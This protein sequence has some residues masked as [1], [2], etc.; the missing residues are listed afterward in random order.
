MLGPSSGLRVQTSYFLCLTALRPASRP[1]LLRPSRILE[2]PFYFQLLG[3]PFLV[4][5]AR[6]LPPDSNT[7]PRCK[8]NG[9][10]SRRGRIARRAPVRL[11]KSGSGRPASGPGVTPL[12]HSGIRSYPQS[13]ARVTPVT[14]AGFSDRNPV[15][16]PSRSWYT[17]AE[18][19]TREL[20]WPH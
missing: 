14:P 18:Y 19:R 5:P 13:S 20:W 15:T 1:R 17:A 12:S 16:A 2:Y 8:S 4:V 9:S 3:L 7:L 6:F 10:R 11:P